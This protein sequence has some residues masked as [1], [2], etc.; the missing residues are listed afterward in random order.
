MDL[1]SVFVTLQNLKG[2]NIM[3]STP[4][5]SRSFLY[6]LRSKDQ[7]SEEHSETEK[8]QRETTLPIPTLTHQRRKVYH[9]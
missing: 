1:G 2:S 9:W 6:Q 4:P 5:S 7:G 8:R 3:L